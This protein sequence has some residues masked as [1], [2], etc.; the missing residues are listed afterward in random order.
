[1]SD[2]E[3]HR[4]VREAFGRAARRY[5][6]SPGHASGD[7][8]RQ[9]L[10][11]AAPAGSERVLDVA[12]GGGHTAIAFALAGCSVVAADL[13][14]AMLAEASAHAA[15][16]GASIQFLPCDAEALPFGEGSF[17]I[18][19]CRIAPHHF[20]HPERFVLEAARV[21]RP[22]G[23][24]VLDDNMAPEDRDLEEFYN[25]FEAWRD[26]SHGWAHPV[27]RWLGW[28]AD[29]GLE[30]EVATPLAAKP[31]PF[32]QWTERIGMEPSEREALA[33]WLL[34]APEPYRSYFR[35]TPGASGGLDSVDGGFALIRARRPLRRGS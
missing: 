6:E 22:E 12:T 7:D 15:R 2:L 35:I 20:P 4:R 18:V 19:A 13:T 25:R 24:F 31:Y 14:P 8:L 32:L 33:A 17:D 23:V 11:L 9:L 34:A 16:R 1:M 30:V 27:S 21:L 5:V 26:P 29:A 10:E 28:M 3:V